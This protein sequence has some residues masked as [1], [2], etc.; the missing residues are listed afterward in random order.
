MHQTRSIFLVYVFIEEIRKVPKNN[1]NENNQNENQNGNQD[2]YEETEQIPVDTANITICKI[3][4]PNSKY[5]IKLNSQNI[6]EY[7]TD[8]GEYKIVIENKDCETLQMKVKLE[9]GLNEKNFKLQPQKACDLTLTVKEYYEKEEEE[10]EEGTNIEN[11]EEEEIEIRPVRNAEVQILKNPDILLIEVI[12][13]RNGLMKYEIGKDDNSLSIVVNKFGYFPSQR[14]FT[15]NEDIEI[16]NGKYI[17][18]M[19][20]ILIRQNLLSK[21]NKVLFISYANTHKNLFNFEYLNI[22]EK[23]KIILKDLQ[24]DEGIFLALFHCIKND[25]EEEEEDSEEKKKKEESQLGSRNTSIIPQNANDEEFDE[26]TKYEEIIRIG[27]KVTPKSIQSTI[28][29]KKKEEEKEEE[30]NQNDE[31]IKEM[32]VDDIIE[33][34]RKVCCQALVYTKISTFSIN[35]PK[36]LNRPEEDVDKSIIKRKKTQ[37]K[38]YVDAKILNVLLYIVTAKKIHYRCKS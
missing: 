25:N 5:E 29:K 35:L 9:K 12:T 18:N 15:R 23:N 32:T 16:E 17:V 28:K 11:K 6:Y 24:E 7:K 2:Y 27:M 22:D 20:I 10:T 38:I 33:Y 30:K 14:Y 4:N 21:S 8:P 13:N 36:V 19:S 34:L 31:N 26:E 37:L 3:E 1:G